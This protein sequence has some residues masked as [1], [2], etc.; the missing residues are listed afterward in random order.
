MRRLQ[1]E[2]TTIAAA[3]AECVYPP[4]VAPESRDAAA[5]T[6]R[7]EAEATCSSFNWRRRLVAASGETSVARRSPGP[8]GRNY[9]ARSRSLIELRRNLASHRDVVLSQ[10]RQQRR[11]AAAQ[12]AAQAAVAPNGLHAAPGNECDAAATGRLP[13]AA[14]AANRANKCADEINIDA[15]NCTARDDYNYYYHLWHYYDYHLQE[16]AARLRCGCCWRRGGGGVG[17]V[18]AA[19][20]RGSPS[21]RSVA[22]AKAATRENKCKT[23][24]RS[25]IAKWLGA[26]AATNC[27]FNQCKS[28][29][30]NQTNTC[31]RQE[32]TMAAC[33]CLQQRERRQTTAT[34]TIT[35]PTPTT[36]TLATTASGKPRN[37][38][39]ECFH[40][41]QRRLCNIYCTLRRNNT[42]NS[43][44]PPPSVVAR[45]QPPHHTPQQEHQQQAAE[46]PHNNNNNSHTTCK[47]S[48]AEGPKPVCGAHLQPETRRN[49]WQTVAPTVVPPLYNLSHY[50]ISVPKF[51]PNN[52]QLEDLNKC[53]R[54]LTSFFP[55]LSKATDF[56]LKF[57]SSCWSPLLQQDW[58]RASKSEH[59]FDN[60]SFVGAE[61]SRPQTT[62]AHL[63]HKLNFHL[64]ESLMRFN[65]KVSV[66]PLSVFVT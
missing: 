30:S 10:R 51:Y 11:H 54:N 41:Q 53:H 35:P 55:R 22:L 20:K 40:K 29:V 50:T 17:A 13:G 33:E 5:T 9:L 63:S 3:A 18:A 12:A 21:T 1:A 16:A 60:K 47:Q 7:A 14:A 2:A 57:F 8:G 45:P 36:A 19:S 49:S 46:P 32:Q 66:S 31:K 42:T 15:C 59:K 56:T 6:R 52:T 23:R 48:F 62:K 65:S 34:T 44:P 37:S 4:A 43:Q 25:T 39:D 28:L 38:A 26:A 58:K 27:I 64:P 24:S 61:A